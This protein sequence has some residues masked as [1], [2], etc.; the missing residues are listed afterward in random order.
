M[1]LSESQINACGERA[2]NPLIPALSLET[3]A[4]SARSWVKDACSAPSL[5]TDASPFRQ[6]GQNRSLTA[7][8]SVELIVA[9]IIE[10][11][12]STSRD[13]RILPIAGSIGGRIDE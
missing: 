9:K 7:T 5:K 2:K 1:L 4:S 12:D 10:I 11:V 8:N 13:C 6:A 3:F